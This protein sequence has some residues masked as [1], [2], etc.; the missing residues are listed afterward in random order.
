MENRTVRVDENIISLTNREFELLKTLIDNKNLAL[1]RDRLI[2]LVWGYD[3]DGDERTVDV[4]IQRLRK[5]LHLE[6]HIKT[7]FKYGYR[8]EI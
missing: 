4:H 2:E 1:S 7:V 5:K 8:L 3:F 6:S